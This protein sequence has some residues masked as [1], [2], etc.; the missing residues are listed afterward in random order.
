MGWDKVIDGK[1]LRFLLVGLCNTAVSLAMMFGFYRI[2]GL[3]YWGS[4]ALAYVLC[5]IMSFF[6]NRA[7]T[8]GNK[9]NVLR[10]GLRFAL[11]IGVCYCVA[12]LIAKPLVRFFLRGA[13]ALLSAAFLDQ[14]AMLVGMAL[15]TGMNYLGQRFFVFPDKKREGS[16][17]E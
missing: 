15:F 10:A 2:I 3:G 4:S 5:S 7:Y 17:A 1:L 9:D 12:Y 16:V 8:F 11:H 13:G 6:L 14:L